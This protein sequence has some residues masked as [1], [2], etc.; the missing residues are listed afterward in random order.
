MWARFLMEGRWEK[1]FRASYLFRIN[2]LWDNNSVVVK[3]SLFF[4]WSEPSSSISCDCDSFM[5]FHSKNIYYEGKVLKL[6]YITPTMTKWMS[7]E[8]V[9]SFLLAGQ[10]S[11]EYRWMI[12]IY[13]FNLK[14]QSKGWKDKQF[15]TLPLSE[16]MELFVIDCD[17]FPC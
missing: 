13:L 15:I 14:A 2:N 1:K 5:R 9:F 12:K 3:I 17:G 16:W 10:T 4:F 6:E 7:G 8:K 11:W